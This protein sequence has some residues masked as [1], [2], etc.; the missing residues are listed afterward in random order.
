[1]RTTLDLDQALMLRLVKE[2]KAASKTEAIHLA[3][4]EYLNM[5]ARESLIESFG[6]VT[7]EPV[8]KESRKLDARHG[9][10]IASQLHGIKARGR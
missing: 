5:L 6:K 2:S 9:V 10:K 7:I 4:Q 3:A 8:Y 1:M